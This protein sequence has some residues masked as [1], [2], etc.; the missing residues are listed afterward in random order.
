MKSG[1]LTV[2]FAT[3]THLFLFAT[4]EKNIVPSV[5]QSAI[6]Y[7]NGAELS[8]KA[9]AFLQ[10]GNNELIIDDISNNVDIASIR[11]HCNESVTIMSVEFSTEYLKPEIKPLFLKKLEDSLSMVEK[12][13][14]K[15]DIQTKT[16]N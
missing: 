4:N 11:V 7:R 8:H 2:L 13:I 5:L 12:E 14:A 15:I 6:V 1:I 10:Q 3:V 9:K 16:D